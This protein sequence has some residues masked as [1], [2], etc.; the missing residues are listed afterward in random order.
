MSGF[1]PAP[2]PGVYPGVPFEEYIAWD[3]LSNTALGYLAESPATFIDYLA[4]EITLDSEALR[5]GRALHQLVL[6]DDTTP[7]L[8]P[9]QRERVAGMRE[10]LLGRARLAEAIEAADEQTELSLVW[11]EEGVLMKG[12]LD[13]P[14]PSVNTI[15]DLKTT[16][17]PARHIFR[18]TAERF[19]YARQASQYLE[20]ARQI[21]DSVR[22]TQFCF[23]VVGS[24][25]PHD[26]RFYTHQADS[27]VIEQGHVQ[28]TGLIRRYRE[29]ME[30]GEWPGPD[31]M[32]G[33][34]CPWEFESLQ[35]EELVVR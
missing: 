14:L 11:E 34:L 2:R 30:R 26:V 23:V 25:P 5:I 13:L 8:T 33:G 22:F 7:L 19:S 20:G 1:T 12:R 17:D 10:A 9:A 21:W 4:G 6:E 3:A 29:C 16:F 35:A 32:I 28:R 24:K 31:E 18:K 15:V 27:D